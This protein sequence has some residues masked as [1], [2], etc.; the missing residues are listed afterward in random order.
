[1]FLEKK[2][3]LEYRSLKKMENFVKILKSQTSS[4]R[5]SISGS[6]VSH[7]AGGD[8]L[9]ISGRVREKEKVLEQYDQNKNLISKT[10]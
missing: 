10:R 4:L 2:R 5:G 3:T 8:V 1:M 7:P 9:T 6:E